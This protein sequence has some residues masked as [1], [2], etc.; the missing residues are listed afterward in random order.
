MLQ[1]K[2]SCDW[3]ESAH[4]I[5]YLIKGTGNA[6]AWQSNAKLAFSFSS[7]ILPLDAVEK[8]GAFAPTGSIFKKKK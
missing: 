4:L 1:N 5:Y 6:C 8:V 7:K 3:I 2:D